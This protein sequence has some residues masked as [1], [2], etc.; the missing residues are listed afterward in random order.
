[1]KKV[2]EAQTKSEGGFK[3]RKLRHLEDKGMPKPIR[4]FLLSF[5]DTIELSVF[6]DA[7]NGRDNA[8]S[9]A[10]GQIHHKTL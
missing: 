1:M 7:L 8:L 2:P 6:L 10:L 9:L 5:E 4:D 3:K